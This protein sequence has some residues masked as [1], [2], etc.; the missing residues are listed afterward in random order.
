M[1]LLKQK[2]TNYSFFYADIAIIYIYILHRRRGVKSL[3]QH[4]PTIL[5]LPG[6]LYQS[7]QVH[8]YNEHCLSTFF[9]IYECILQPKQAKTSENME[10]PT[11]PPCSSTT[12]TKRSN[13]GGECIQQLCLA[14]QRSFFCVFFLF[15][16]F[17]SSSS[18]YQHDG[19]EGRDHEDISWIIANTA[20]TS[21]SPASSPSK[22]TSSSF[23]S[24]SSCSSCSSLSSSVSSARL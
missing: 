5:L 14:F 23:V 1:L 4:L 6:H 20:C 2:R 22:S 19:G 8:H 9:P 7:T 16:F 11:S 15:F 18:F 12:T 17:C 3:N 10:L 21:T 13:A 24:S